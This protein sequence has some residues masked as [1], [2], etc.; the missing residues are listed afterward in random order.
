MVDIPYM[1]KTLLVLA[2]GYKN[3]DGRNFCTSEK[4]HFV[5]FLC[6]FVLKMDGM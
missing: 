6:R 1:I 4:I 3:T 5:L 2:I